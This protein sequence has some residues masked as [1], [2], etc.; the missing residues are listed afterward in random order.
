M[1]HS[2]ESGNPES[3]NLLVTFQR[4][5]ATCLSPGGRGRP[6]QRPGRV[7]GDFGGTSTWIPACA[8]KTPSSPFHSAK[9][10]HLLLSGFPFARKQAWIPAYAGMTHCSPSPSRHPGERGK[11]GFLLA[12]ES[13]I[14]PI[15][16]AK[17]FQQCFIGRGRPRCRGNTRSTPPNR[18]A[19]HPPRIR[20]PGSRRRCSRCQ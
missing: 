8:G 19:D 12:Q 14:V 1:Y 13:H 15:R 17:M 10:L 4:N 16:S 7:R 20:I 18:A 3:R 6:G 5:E 11:P 2:H 9:V